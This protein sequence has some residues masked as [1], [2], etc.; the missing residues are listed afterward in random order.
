MGVFERPNLL[1][2]LGALVEDAV[3]VGN[4]NI[5][6]PAIRKVI[7]NSFSANQINAEA[8]K[9]GVTPQQLIDD[10]SFLGQSIAMTQFNQRQGLGSGTSVS[11][12]EQIMVNAMGPT[13]QDT[14]GSFR[15]K[16]AF[17][18]NKSQF[19]IELGRAMKE[20]GMQYDDFESTPAFKKM[21]SEYQKKQTGVV[22]GDRPPAPTGA[23]T[24][25]F[26]GKE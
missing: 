23:R 13:I 10:L 15:K 17:M 16:L 1:A 18:K 12:F 11:N 7:T 20:S 5:G 19:E 3:R 26:L 25:R 2:G 4:F 9:A 6:L 14:V 24:F 21:F 8:R 22:Y